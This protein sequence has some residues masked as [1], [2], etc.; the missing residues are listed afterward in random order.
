MQGPLPIFSSLFLFHMLPQ[1]S[2]GNRE[3][4]TERR[5]NSETTSRQ[6]HVTRL[7]TE[8]QPPSF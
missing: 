5:Y 2:I 1:S 4:E 7:Q 6:P 8:V 3:I